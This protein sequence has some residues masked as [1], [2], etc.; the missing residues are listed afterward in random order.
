[1]IRLNRITQADD[2]R[3]TPLIA[4]YEEAFPAEERREIGQL[5]QL[6]ENNESMFLNAIEC[7]GEPAGLFIYWDMGDFYYLEHLAVFNHMR[8][9][10]IGRR[11]LDW[12]AT[13]LPGLRLLEVEPDD[14]EM[15]L[16]RINYYKRNGYEVIT[17]D[18]IQPSYSKDEDACALWIMG[19]EK[20]EHITQYID[21]IKQR[22]YHAP[23]Q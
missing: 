6:I 5:K 10:E 1:M 2:L 8:N 14:N 4:L 21:I 20:T 9:K 15:A 22:V 13:N 17:S 16:R 18:Y 23:R 11:V 12:I 3:L 19:N 7:D